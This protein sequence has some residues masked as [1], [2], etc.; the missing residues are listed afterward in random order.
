MKIAEALR[1]VKDKYFDEEKGTTT[2]EI[3]D[4]YRNACSQYPVLMATAQH[5]WAN[6]LSKDLP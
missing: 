3:A 1:L 4:K 2:G 6:E 5:I